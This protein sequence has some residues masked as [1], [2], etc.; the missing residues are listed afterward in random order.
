MKY[1]FIALMLLASVLCGCRT[2]KSNDGESSTGFIL[3]GNKVK[4]EAGSP[5]ESKLKLTQ[6]QKEDI[7]QGFTVTASVSPR[8]D[9]Y[10]EVGA[11]FNGRVTRSAVRLGDRVYRG[12]VLFEMSSPDFMAAVKDYLESNN[13]YSVASANL[14]RKA[15]LRESGVVSEREWEDAKREA[16]D[17]ETALAL[18]RQVLSVFGVNPANVQMGQPLR[19]I[20]P[21]SG[22]VVKNNLVL[23]Q[24]L[25][26]D[27][28]KKHSYIPIHHFNSRLKSFD[29]IIEKAVRYGIE[30]PINNIDEIK[31]E[32]LDI[33][34]IRVVCNYEEDLH[35]MANLLLNQEE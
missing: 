3:E 24:I 8:P 33:A 20:S 23:G 26:D 28:D 21:I 29:S 32:V 34:G 25:S 9:G 22:T 15:S 13:A 10:A 7:N 27:F 2:G 1:N 35:R 30:D 16:S 5:L 14:S 19:V 12:Q 11:P 17:A 18:S 4:I 31:R 6:L